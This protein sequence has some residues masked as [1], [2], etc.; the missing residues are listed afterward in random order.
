MKAYIKSID[1]RVWRTILKRLSSPVT[2]NNETKVVT[3]KPEERWTT[4]EESFANNNFQAFNVIFVTIDVTQFKLISACESVRDVWVVL[5]N[6]HERTLAVKISKLQMLA[7]RFE[8]L[9]ILE[10]EHK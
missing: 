3:L 9:R 6:A 8:D 2:T 1:E 4:E 10:D 7:S 5:Q